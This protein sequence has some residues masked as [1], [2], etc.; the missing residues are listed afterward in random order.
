MNSIQW[1]CRFDV[2]G[3]VIGKERPKFTKGRA[4]TPSKTK[5]Y[6]ELIKNTFVSKYNYLSKK[7]IRIKIIAYFAPPKSASKLKKEKM[8]RNELACTKKP[9]FDNIAKSVCD[10]LNNVAYK[11]DSQIVDSIVLKRWGAFEKI[12]VYIEEVGEPYNN[13]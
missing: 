8:L 13:I 9:D 1:K 11:D 4:Y 2:I 10:A 12:T 5:N 3:E 6:E 7:A